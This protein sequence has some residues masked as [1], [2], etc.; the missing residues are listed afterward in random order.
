MFCELIMSWFEWEK[1]KQKINCLNFKPVCDIT[2][3]NISSFPLFSSVKKLFF[4]KMSF[5]N[6]LYNSFMWNFSFNFLI[7]YSFLGIKNTLSIIML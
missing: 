4:Y 7:S 1:L 5:F 3:D 6:V 2:S